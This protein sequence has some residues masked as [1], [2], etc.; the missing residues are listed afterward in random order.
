MK[1]M[2]IEAFKP[3]QIDKVYERFKKK[4]RLLPIG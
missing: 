2:V 1:C 4:G 3:K